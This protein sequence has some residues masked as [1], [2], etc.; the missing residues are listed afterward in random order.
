MRTSCSEATVI[1][2]IEKLRKNQTLFKLH[3]EHGRTGLCAVFFAGTFHFVR[4]LWKE[5]F[6]YHKERYHCIWKS[7]FSLDACCVNKKRPFSAK[8][9]RSMEDRRK[10][11]FLM[12]EGTSNRAIFHASISK[13]IGISLLV[14]LLSTENC[15]FHHSRYID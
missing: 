5:R 8:L 1:H 2:H 14:F 7:H 12:L 6:P 10:Q 15:F 9:K 11:S 13:I 4:L 3:F